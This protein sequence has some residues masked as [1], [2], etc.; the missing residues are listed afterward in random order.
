M[1]PFDDLIMA[2]LQWTN[3]LLS[4][5]HKAIYIIHTKAFCNRETVLDKCEID[6]NKIYTQ[7]RK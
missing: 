2:L 4:I 3:L 1:V 6:N 5:S 7:E